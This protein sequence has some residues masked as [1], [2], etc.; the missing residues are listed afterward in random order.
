MQNTFI[1]KRKWPTGLHKKNGRQRSL[2]SRNFVY[3]L[4]ED[5]TVKKKPNLEVVLTSFVDGIGK[6]GDVVSL[7]ESVAYNKLLLPGLAVY[8]TPENIAKYAN[9]KTETVEEVKHS[10]PHAQ[11]VTYFVIYC[12]Y[13]KKNIF[14]RL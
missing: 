1:L 14:F 5:T 10:S 12:R 2:R 9:L 6:K 11:R 3:E 4:V 8:K 13:I 7:K